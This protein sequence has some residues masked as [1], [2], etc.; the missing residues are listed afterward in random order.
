MLIY[1]QTLPSN[2]WT[3]KA[4]Q[5]KTEKQEDLI[6]CSFRVKVRAEECFSRLRMK[7]ISEVQWTVNH[8]RG[9]K[10]AQP[11]ALIVCVCVCI[12]GQLRR[13]LFLFLSVKMAGVW[14]S[15]G[16]CGCVKQLGTEGWHLVKSLPVT[17]LRVVLELRT[18]AAN[19]FQQHGGTMVTIWTRGRETKRNR[20]SNQR[21]SY[22]TIW[23][24][25][26]D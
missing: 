22:I 6:T 1:R 5:L 18:N 19:A 24:V 8:T 25:M 9:G 26:R 10:A 14:T 3:R 20:Y 21:D 12:N 2:G 11:V 4:Q 16:V 7:T 13:F 17:L 23:T 15:V